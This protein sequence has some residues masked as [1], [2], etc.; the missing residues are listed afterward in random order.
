MLGDESSTRR[1][2]EMQGKRQAAFR[3]EGSAGN[4]NNVARFDP[5]RRIQGPCNP[6]ED[7]LELPLGPVSLEGTYIVD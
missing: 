5:S 1:E 6:G 7:N 4:I 3:E 2:S